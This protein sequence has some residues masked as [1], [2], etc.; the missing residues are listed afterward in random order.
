MSRWE[1]KETL[2]AGEL[3]AELAAA[4]KPTLAAVEAQHKGER[5]YRAVALV[6][7]TPVVRVFV[8]HQDEAGNVLR[9]YQGR[10]DAAVA[11]AAGR[12]LVTG[13]NESTTAEAREQISGWV[14]R[15]ATLAVRF[16]PDFETASG[17]V[18]T[19][20]HEVELFTLCQEVH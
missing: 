5:P 9:V 1:R 3:L 20:D 11:H 19:G 18:V 17:S 14:D 13:L 12:F 2:R 8:E 6:L 7:T 16:H 15:G 10:T 4:L